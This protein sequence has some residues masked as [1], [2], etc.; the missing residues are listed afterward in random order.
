MATRKS[1]TM[2]TGR[3]PLDFAKAVSAAANAA[4]KDG[5]FMAAATPVTREL[6]K[7]WFEE[8]FTF[9]RA[10]KN[11]LN[12]H[13]G[14][15]QAI[16]NAIYLHE[17]AGA[18]NPADAY[19][20][21]APELAAAE[22]GAIAT[23]VAK[24]KYGYPKYCVKMATGTGK[25]W[26]MHALLIWQYL[27]AKFSF[28]DKEHKEPPFFTKNFL[29]VA[30]GLIVYERLLDA[31]CGKRAGDGEKRDFATSDIKSCEAL[32]VPPRFREALYGFLQNSF[33]R[34]EDFG[35]KTT[36]DGVLAVMNWHAFLGDDE[37]SGAQP[38][39]ESGSDE[40]SI[41]D[42]L[43]PAKPG[44]TAGN[45]LEA[46]DAA[47]LRGG[48]LDFLKELPD[49][50]LVNDEAH[51]LY[52]RDGD[53][54]EAVVWQ[55]G[56]DVLTAGK[57]R[58]LQLDFTATP[59]KASGSGRNAR[60]DFVPHIAVDY[61]L[62]TAIRQGRVKTIV[63]DQRKD[64]TGRLVNLDYNAVREGRRVVG[65]SDGQRLMLRAG[66]AK[67][68]Y[69]EKEFK[70][71][72]ASRR[73]KMMVVCEDTAVTPF[74][75]NFLLGEGL[76]AEDVLTVDSNRQGEVKP[77]EWER[78]KGRL[79]SIDKR[80]KPRV[81]V[82]VLMLREG[83]DVNN[84]CVIV[85]LRASNAQILLEQTLGRGLRLMWREPDYRETKEKARRQLLVEK[86]EPCA[87]LDSLYIIEH[88]AFAAFYDQMAEEG[89]L[90]AQ[91][92]ESREGGGTDDLVHSVLKDGC[93]R[94]DMFWP[95]VL[96][97]SEE[98]FGDGKVPEEELEPFTLYPLSRLREMFAKPGEVFV[99]RELL[100][101]TA[102]GEYRV[103][104]NIF[105]A[106]CYND[107]LQGVVDSISRR[108]VRVGGKQTRAMPALQVNLAAIAS[109]VDRYVRERLFG[110]PFDPFSGN[111][112]K[113]LLCLNGAVTEHVVK[114]I[115]ELV[116]RIETGTTRV[117][118]EVAKIRF[119]SV[120]GF[121]VRRG[122]SLALEKTIYTLTGFPANGGGLER[123][124]AEFIDSDGAVE[125]FVKV[126]EAKHVFAR[127]AYLRSDGLPGE[128]IPDFLVAA[129]ERMYLVETKA[130]KDKNT[131][132][133]QAKRRAA[134]EWCKTINAL[135]PE[136]R[137]NREWAYLLLTDRDFYAYRSANATFADLA[138]YA[139]LTESGLK[140]EFSF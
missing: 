132:N 90:G 87:V 31:F 115:G 39:R 21:I 32:F 121:I 13:E 129:K 11:L 122:C 68:R 138:A 63:I 131:A 22:G 76:D 114:Q 104:A 57:D 86:V 125:M 5:S 40:R 29:F 75:S 59:Y 17:V 27:N 28:S 18:A 19:A 67:L 6:L 55:R 56:I 41:L 110:E 66:L 83:F 93:E 103:H 137:D 47:F 10:S 1:K 106:R 52:G 44:T 72:N 126:N 128:Y 26:V 105:N 48:R 7:F 25:T 134:H 139:E 71:I 15:R 92:A 97:D 96:R 111:D 30:P 117:E 78:I 108:F 70:R 38:S 61:D 120:P 79:F 74:V 116:Y 65:L 64:L 51:H 8:P 69:L 49:L 109:T 14:Q 12:F 54:E 23:E 42:D 127:I 50:M 53:D 100:A 94:L 33:V 98:I 102:F 36:G 85:P 73:P 107:Y 62:A 43:L 4:W 24:D 130:E 16:L 3:I 82:S 2:N 89:L 135:P 133:V 9:E 118:A 119:S 35:R 95:V 84:V 77:D 88:P 20:K 60:R 140:G 58:F 91:T 123:D 124:F 34:K 101:K 112:W 136:E 80:E 81:I 113:V 45:T 37:G 99:G 46:L